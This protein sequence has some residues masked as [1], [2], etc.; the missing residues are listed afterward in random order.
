MRELIVLGC[1]A[2]D[3]ISGFTGIVIAITDWLNGCRRITIAP[4]ELK[5]GKPIDSG[6]FDVEQ[7]AFVDDGLKQTAKPPTGGPSIAPTRSAD[8]K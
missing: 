2:K 6:T 5:D 4:Q 1:K 8:P 3:S 7:V